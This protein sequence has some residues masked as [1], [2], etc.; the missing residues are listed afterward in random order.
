MLSNNLGWFL[1]LNPEENTMALERHTIMSKVAMA[2][3][4]EIL[5][6]KI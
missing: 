4:Y 1:V 5:D 2:L 3:V 6:I